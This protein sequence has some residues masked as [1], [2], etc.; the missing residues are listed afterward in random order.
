MLGLTPLEADGSNGSQDILGY[1]LA[2]E[3]MLD[4]EGNEVTASTWHGK[5]A[6]KLKLPPGS[7]AKAEQM[8]WLAQ[9]YTP[10]GLR[11]KLAENAGPDH[12]IGFDMTF[13]TPKDVGV[14]IAASMAK[15]D[16]KTANEIIGACKKAV[17]TT[18]TKLEEIGIIE[19]KRGQAGVDYH[20]SEGGLWSLHTHLAN[21][22]LEPHLHFHALLYNVGFCNGKWGGIETRAL[23]DNKFSIDKLSQAEMAKNIAELGFGIKK[24]YGVDGLGKQTGV[25]D[26]GIVGIPQHLLDKFSTRH[27]EIQEY[28]KENP[29]ALDAALKTRKHKDEP[30]LPEMVKSW[31]EDFELFEADRP[32]VTP[33]FDS[34]KGRDHDVAKITPEEIFEKLHKNEA[35]MTR[36]RVLAR[37]AMEHPEKGIAGVMEEFERFQNHDEVVKVKPTKV[38][39]LKTQYPTMKFKLDRWTTKGMLE[40]EQETLTMALQH[41]EDTQHILDKDL[42][43]KQVAKLNK[44]LQKD[45]GD[46]K[47]KLAEEQV[48]AILHCTTNEGSVQIIQGRAGT[49]KTVSTKCIH[50][51]Y[52]EAGY[53]VVGGSTGWKAAKILEEDSGAESEALAKILHDLKRQHRVLD[54]KTVLIVDEAGMVSTQDGHA[55]MKAVLNAGGKII[56][57]GD[58][59]QLQAVG[60]G[61]MMRTLMD[62]VGF[63]ELKDIRRQKSEEDRETAQMFYD[64]ADHKKG[65]HDPREA[66]ALGRKFFERLDE[67]GH[68]A[69]FET[70]KDAISAIAKDYVYDARSLDQK[71]ILV[72]E[73]SEGR[74]INKRIHD[75]RKKAGELGTA[76]YKVNTR[77]KFGVEQLTLSKGD[78][79]VFKEPTRFGANNGDVGTILSIYQDK[80]GIHNFEV[81]IDGKKERIV[82]FDESQTQNFGYGYAVTLHAAQGFTG[83]SI[84]H[85]GNVK[86]M[87]QQS[88]LVGF[89]RMKENYKLYINKDCE[90]QLAMNMGR[91]DQKEVAIE[92]GVVVKKG[93]N[94]ERVNRAIEKA[95][96][97]VAQAQRARVAKKPQSKHAN[98]R[99][100]FKSYQMPQVSAF[101]KSRWEAMHGKSKKQ[102]PHQ[103]NKPRQK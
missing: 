45:S 56:L 36:N 87:T 39:G 46:P 14:L 49:G 31:R 32:G 92:E 85:F 76:Q 21:R 64:G 98:Q 16:L 44:K 41:R 54:D 80:N 10:D 62:S 96:Q 13:N 61:G 30:T 73:N 7:E 3:Y 89:T 42:V 23:F 69:R 4:A 1:L 35:V 83:K 55:A 67:R 22:N 15:G 27:Q 20:S 40:K 100:A 81:K 102:A 28:L 53:S 88:A 34:L 12:K 77:T 103:P 8:R 48:N 91:Q 78:R 79:I 5:L 24:K 25:D 84:L 70:E 75:L 17:E 99:P 59:M 33:D 90:E 66:R 52:K 71:I 38:P 6:E 97:K 86:M 9:A 57:Q 26:W 43:M 37:I 65:E 18:L 95:R 58:T 2:T 47:A 11:T 94:L 93:S 50:D 101:I 19:C 74:A 68:I 82:R 72:H 60:A 63:A 29:G 51:A